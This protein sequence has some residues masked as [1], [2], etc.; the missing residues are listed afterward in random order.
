MGCLFRQ[1]ENRNFF[2]SELLIREQLAG[3]RMMNKNESDVGEEQRSL[4]AGAQRPRE[5]A[6][7][8]HFLGRS[9]SG[10]S[11]PE[12]INEILAT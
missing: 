11:P 8:P 7:A 6:P 9:V 10:C 3:G 2:Q 4:L 5:A 12:Q 1:E